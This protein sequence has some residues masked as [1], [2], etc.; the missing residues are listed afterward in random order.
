MHQDD[1]HAEACD[2]AHQVAAKNDALQQ[3]VPEV[4]Y[5]PPHGGRME[6]PPAM[7]S[8]GGDLLRLKALRLQ[9]IAMRVGGALFATYALAHGEWQEATV[10]ATI[11]SPITTTLIYRILKRVR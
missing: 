1:W 7:S 8:H 9:E 10:M 4:P 6:P 11:A 2:L 5:V 3:P